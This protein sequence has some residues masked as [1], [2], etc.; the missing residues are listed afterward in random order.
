MSTI[1]RILFVSLILLLST[2][3]IFAGRYYD[4]ATGR[5]LTV[6]P[7]ANLRPYLS[8]YNYCQ[9][10]P[11]NRIDPNGMLDTRLEF[12]E[13][14]NY[15]GAVED[16]KNEITGAIVNKDREVKRTFQFNSTL[17]ASSIFLGKANPDGLKFMGININFENSMDGFIDIGTC[18]SKF[19]NSN[20]Q[21]A[22]EQ[23]GKGGLM[24][25]V[26]YLAVENSNKLLLIDGVAYN[27]Y[28]AGNYM[29]GNAMNR[30]DIP[31]WITR[32]GAEVNA[33]VNS[34]R[35]NNKG[36]GLSLKDDSADIMAYTRGYYRGK[37]W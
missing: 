11:L 9:N 16:G 10:N 34:N 7:K 17:D 5:W 28:D 14:G 37:K 20:I 23:S 35:D 12:D 30:L 19:S 21:Y 25:F 22:A 26:Q 31:Y 36:I 3:S 6:D 1:Y 15:V 8:P 32:I 33:I 13:K 29:W 24:D 18:L 4:S 27:A 2:Q